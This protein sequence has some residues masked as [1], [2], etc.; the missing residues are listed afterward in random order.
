MMAK[1]SISVF[2]IFLGFSVFLH[3]D[4]TVKQISAASVINEILK[5]NGPKAAIEKAEEI[6]SDKTGI[7]KLDETE[8]LKLAEGYMNSG[9]YTEAFTMYRIT[10]KLIPTSAEALTKLG[11]MYG[12]MGNNELAL[13]SFEKILEIALTSTVDE[14]TIAEA[15]RNVFEFRNE[16]TEKPLF[17]TGQNTNIKGPYVGQTP[18]GLEPKPFA[19]GIVSTFGGFEFSITF[20]PD[21][22]EIY[23]NRSADIFTSRL[24]EEGWTVPEPA[25]FNT[26]GLDHEARIT[27]DGKI[28]FFGSV[29]VQPGK[30]E[31]EYAIWAMNRTE[32]GWGEPNYVISGAMYIS[33]SAKGEIYATDIGENSYGGIFKI[34]YRDGKYLKG[35]T[36]KIGTD[37]SFKPAHPCIAPDGSYIIFDARVRPD[38]AEGDIFISFAD[39]GG[40]WNEPQPIVEINTP[41][42]EMAASISP[43][44][45]YLFFHSHRDICWIDIK[46]LEKYKAKAD[47]MTRSDPVAGTQ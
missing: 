6:N 42:D 21:G 18:P 47:G 41:G 11:E 38:R 1:C 46:I 26:P 15:K 24:N 22:N 20:S 29:R 40:G 3:C 45:K 19:P 12:N 25:P 23:F 27:S 36:Q 7:Y 2:F 37:S 9:K 10:R 32:E 17:E 34:I 44:G 31:P 4:N 43:D 8:F 13:K 14:N 30:T 5:T 35:E 33:T 39:S 28:M 16:T